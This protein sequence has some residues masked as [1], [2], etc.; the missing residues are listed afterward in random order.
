[1][2]NLFFDGSYVENLNCSYH[3]KAKCAKTSLNSSLN[4]NK[5]VKPL[6]KKSN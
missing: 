3:A 6:R 4:G 1:M 5:N 2:M